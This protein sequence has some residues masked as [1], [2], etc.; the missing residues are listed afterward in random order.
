MVYKKKW[1]AKEMLFK[2]IQKKL[3]KN[4]PRLFPFENH[5]SSKTYKETWFGINRIFFVFVNFEPMNLRNFASCNFFSRRLCRAITSSS[6]SRKSEFWAKTPRWV[7]K[8][9]SYDSREGDKD[10]DSYYMNTESRKRVLVPGNFTP[11]NSCR[12]AGEVNTF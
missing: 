5:Q 4:H 7:S 11:Q 9:R 1:W 3:S 2:K 10:K 8:S 6:A 12:L